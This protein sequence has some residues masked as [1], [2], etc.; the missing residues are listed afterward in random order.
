M[1]RTL[2]LIAFLT[3]ALPALAL[4]LQLPVNAQQTLER[5][6]VLGSYEVPLAGF[7]NG[8]I[9]TETIEGRV[10]TQAWRI[11]GSELT[12]LQLLE[13]L[14]DQLTKDG[15]TILLD[16]ASKACGGFDFRFATDVLPAPNMYVDI[17]NYRFVSAAI[18]P[19]GALNEVATVLVSRS[20]AAGFIQIVHA[21][22]EALETAHQARASSEP[23]P[24]VRSGSGG[25]LADE[26]MEEGH[27]ILADL[28]FATGSSDLSSGDFSSLE[29][30]AT[31]LSKNPN[32][33][34]ALVGHTDS[35]GALSNNIALSK[36][37]A[38]SVLK[39]LANVYDI[40]QAQMQAEGMGYLA[41]VASNL[42]QEGRDLNRRV[43]A[44]LLFAE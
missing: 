39:R 31:Y 42:T 34:I 3:W 12:T 33:K 23:L 21:S 35:Q 15:F 1:T 4:E 32:I 24:Q 19:I 41:P 37:R 25:E 5:D 17:R 29:A 8:V 22:K 10:N 26:L 28:H 30:L 44:I 43:E 6:V 13:P 40:P 2:T 9:P 18:G 36:K 20:S 16:C 7:A 27:V 11:A 38:Q 14:R